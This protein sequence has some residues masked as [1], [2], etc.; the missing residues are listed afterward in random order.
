MIN[1]HINKTGQTD[2]SIKWRRLHCFPTKKKMKEKENY[3]VMINR[4]RIN[5]IA[6][7]T[8]IDILIY[9]HETRFAI[10]PLV[11]PDH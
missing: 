2:E 3:L 11:F 8:V 9:F 1:Q 10:I 7:L 4:C 6:E 5:Y